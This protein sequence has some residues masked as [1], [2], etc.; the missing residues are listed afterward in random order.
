MTTRT[1][2][3]EVGTDL[4]ELQDVAMDDITDENNDVIYV[5][6]TFV[7]EDTKRTPTR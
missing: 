3:R 2:T 5:K 1:E 6:W 4:F 7:E